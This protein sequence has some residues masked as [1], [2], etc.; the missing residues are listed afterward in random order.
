MRPAGRAVTLQHDV[1]KVLGLLGDSR[2]AEE[3]FLA[4]SRVRRVSAPDG[5]VEWTVPDD[6]TAE[7]DAALR[8]FALRQAG[9]M[10]Q[11]ALLVD[12]GVRGV[13]RG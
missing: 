8:V 1:R 13:G 10:R 6:W 11:T 12:P 5:T 9:L 3:K 7:E 2:R 4:G